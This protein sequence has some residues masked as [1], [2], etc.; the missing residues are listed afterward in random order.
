MGLGKH[1]W[2]PQISPLRYAP[3]EMTNLWVVDDPFPMETRLQLG[4][5]LVISTE[6]Q[7]SGEICGFHSRS[8]ARINDVV[9]GLQRR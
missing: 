6:A 2:K 3:V 1:E 4:N 8:T 7:R 9:L 5:N